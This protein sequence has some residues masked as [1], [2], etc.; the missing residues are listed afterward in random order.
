MMNAP[1]KIL[2]TYTTNAGSTKEVAERIA[3]NI[4]PEAGSVEVEPVERITDLSSYAGVVLGGPMIL[5]WHRRAQKFYKKQRRAL[6]GIPHHIFM[7]AM[8]VTEWGDA[9]VIT[10]DPGIVSPPRVAGKLSFKEKFTTVGHYAAPVTGKGKSPT[11][12]SV[13]IFGGKLD[14]TKLKI[15]QMLFVMLV[16][17]EAPAEKREWNL[18]E[19]WA[20]NLVF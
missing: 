17:G 16:V 18:I 1:K 20:K 19:E 6:R 9:G 15:H 10:V 14:Y 12:A 2:V 8:K 3:A 11:P 7:T 5:G 13:A 4:P